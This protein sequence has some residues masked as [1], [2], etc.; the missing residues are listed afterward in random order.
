[1]KLQTL[2][3]M[4]VPVISPDGSKIAYVNGDADTTP[5]LADTGWRKG[6]SM[7][8]REQNTMTVSKKKRLLNSWP[9][10]PPYSGIPFKWPFFESDS[11]S[12]VY[13]ETETGENCSSA[14]SA[15]RTP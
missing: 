2:P 14:S 3:T 11:K 4:M 12:L 10:T 1:F 13:V 5:G 6:L 7:L 15:R 9:A 8:E